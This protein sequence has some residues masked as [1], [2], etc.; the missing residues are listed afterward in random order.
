MV[1]VLLVFMWHSATKN[2]SVRFDGTKWIILTMG[3]G[4]DNMVSTPNSRN[5]MVGQNSSSL[6]PYGGVCDAHNG[7]QVKKKDW[8]ASSEER[9]HIIP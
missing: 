1:H 2:K 3:L 4:R 6:S 5:T 9:V 8:Q 7:G